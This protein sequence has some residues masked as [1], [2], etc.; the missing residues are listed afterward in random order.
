M[1][2]VILQQ[3]LVCCWEVLL[4]YFRIHLLILL[5]PFSVRCKEN[6]LLY[7]HFVLGYDPFLKYEQFI[8]FILVLSFLQMTLVL[9]IIFFFIFNHQSK[10][11]IIKGSVFKGS[12]SLIWPICI[13]GSAPT[14]IP[15]CS[16]F[17]SNCIFSFHNISG[18]LL[19]IE[20]HDLQFKQSPAQVCEALGEVV[21]FSFLVST[22][23]GFLSYVLCLGKKASEHLSKI[24]LVS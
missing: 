16:S 13:A 24:S 19:F 20:L 14:F 7:W 21:L 18:K 1:I 6:L 2:W 5:N 17:V 23:P 22:F 3:V 15:F 8:F 9:S 11:H 12:G 10:Y 4:T